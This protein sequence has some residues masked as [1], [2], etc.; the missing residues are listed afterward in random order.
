M[1]LRDARSVKAAVLYALFGT[2]CL[3]LH[4]TGLLFVVACGSAVWL[5]LLVQGASARQALLKWTALNGL[6]LLLGVPYYYRAFT[7][8]K[9]GVINY[10][11][12]AGSI[13]SSIALR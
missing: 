3:Y 4:A 8:S 10:M 6:V 2:L 12:A 13:K 9:T 1:F 11:P 5:F 7:A